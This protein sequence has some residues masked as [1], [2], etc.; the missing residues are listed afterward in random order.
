MTPLQ[1]KRK[2]TAMK[3]R[4]LKP[5]DQFKVRGTANPRENLKM[6][7]KPFRMV[8]LGTPVVFWFVGLKTGNHHSFPGWTE[9]RLI[10]G[11]RP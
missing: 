5:G 3:I 7:A 8:I 4:D 2:E 11:R 1:K 10:S 9:V 6:L